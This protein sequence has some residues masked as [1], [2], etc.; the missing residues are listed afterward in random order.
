MDSYLERK[1]PAMNAIILTDLHQV[2]NCVFGKLKSQN[3]FTNSVLLSE[4][5]KHTKI[6]WKFYKYFERKVRL[7]EIEQQLERIEKQAIESC[8][9]NA[10]TSDEVEDDDSSEFTR[11][12]EQTTETPTTTTK[13]SQ[14]D[15][16]FTTPVYKNYEGSVDDDDDDETPQTTENI[17]EIL[18][19]EG[20]GDGYD[21]DDDDDE[22]ALKSITRLNEGSGDYTD[23]YD[24]ED[25][26]KLH[27]KIRAEHAS[28]RRQREISSK[29]TSV[30]KDDDFV[31]LK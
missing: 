28:K 18:K 21:D 6:S 22:G 7:T 19:N 12:S 25:Q 5:L 30:L 16:K 24:L 15:K 10:E 2:S 11:I 14:S 17:N 20:S 9:G 29:Q 31:F 23:D 26:K 1:K 4:V 3:F 13:S 8:G 27:E